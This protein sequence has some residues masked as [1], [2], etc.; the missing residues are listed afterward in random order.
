MMQDILE[1]VDHL[2]YC[3]FEDEEG[4]S[5]SEEESSTEKEEE[6]DDQKEIHVSSDSMNFVSVSSLNSQKGLKKENDCQDANFLEKL[7]VNTN[8][9]LKMIEIQNNEDPKKNRSKPRKKEAMSPQ[10]APATKSFQEDNCQNIMAHPN[11]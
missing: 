9:L 11:H 7:E 8:N 3:E 5:E 1:K 4:E 10:Q 6:K 2:Y